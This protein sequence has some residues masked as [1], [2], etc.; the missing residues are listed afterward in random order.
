VKKC[1]L[2]WY[3]HVTQISGLAKREHYREQYKEGDEEADR[4]NNE[5]ATSESGL[6]LRGTNCYG[7]QRTTGSGGS[8]LQNLHWCPHGP[9]DYHYGM[10]EGGLGFQEP[11][12]I[13]SMPTF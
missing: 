5:K 2:K 6:A 11:V 10:A 7:K 13:N 4:E 8:W 3:R 12:S 9:W 1:K